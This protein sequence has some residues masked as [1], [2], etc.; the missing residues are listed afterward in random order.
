MKISKKSW[1][2]RMLS[3]FPWK[4]NEYWGPYSLCGY[5]WLVVWTFFFCLIVVPVGIAMVVGAA[6]FV[7]LFI[8]YPIL[9]IWLGTEPFIAAVSAIIDTFL[10][11]WLWC[12]YRKKYVGSEMCNETASL[13]G[14]YMHAKH[15]K[16]CPLLDFD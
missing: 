12:W 16:V 13:V 5:F 6:A 15:R 11:V 4:V 10:L 8:F 3:F 7:G 1:H 9:Q 14:Q 2:Y